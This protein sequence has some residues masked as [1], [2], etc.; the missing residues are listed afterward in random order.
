MHNSVIIYICI[1]Y[2]SIIYNFIKGT[3]SN[4]DNDKDVIDDTD[5]NAS[6]SRQKTNI[7]MEQPLGKGNLKQVKLIL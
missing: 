2:N 1:T 7:T 3:S 6:S 4:I 5:S